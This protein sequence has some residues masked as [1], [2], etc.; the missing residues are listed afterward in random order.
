MYSWG[1]QVN[2]QDWGPQFLW[3]DMWFEHVFQSFNYADG[4]M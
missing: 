3:E 2:L 1:L 4:S